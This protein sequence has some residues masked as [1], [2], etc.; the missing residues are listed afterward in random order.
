M[1][2]RII[3]SIIILYGVSAQ[4]IAQETA[5]V[6]SVQEVLIG[7]QT[8]RWQLITI[9]DKWLQK[10]WINSDYDQIY[11]TL[12]GPHWNDIGL[13]APCSA[14]PRLLLGT[15]DK[16]GKREEH[17]LQCVNMCSTNDNEE[18][19]YRGL[20]GRNSFLEGITAQI[21]SDGEIEVVEHFKE[22]FGIDRNRI[23]DINV[24]EKNRLGTD[25]KI[26]KYRLSATLLKNAVKR[27]YNGSCI[28]FESNK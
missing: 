25:T 22:T 18:S 26:R 16:N 19:L 28:N 14:P 2:L 15:E 24:V 17:L 20:W 11:L 8:S 12:R 6:S 3:L 5:R 4:A 9:P 21:L 27:Q 13:Y 1:T 7:P 23:G 10:Y